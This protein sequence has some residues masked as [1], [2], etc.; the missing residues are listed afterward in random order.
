M[1][2]QD[3]EI[4]PGSVNCREIYSSGLKAGS[5]A[6]DGP[7][8]ST[9]PLI[10]SPIS[11]AIFGGSDETRTRDLRRDRPFLSHSHYNR[12]HKIC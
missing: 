6:T 11:E 9:D 12:F 4:K 1:G 3:A 8:G 2:C 5:N 10:K 7:L